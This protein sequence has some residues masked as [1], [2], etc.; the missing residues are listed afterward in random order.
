MV[1]SSAK[2]TL[3]ILIDNEYSGYCII[4]LVRMLTDWLQI[5]ARFS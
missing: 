1:S 3:H 5:L 4:Q 2:M